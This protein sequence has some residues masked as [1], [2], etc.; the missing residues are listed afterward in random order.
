MSDTFSWDSAT[1]PL[2]RVKEADDRIKFARE[3]RESIEDYNHHLHD[4]AWELV[5]LGKSDTSKSLLELIEQASL[6]LELAMPGTNHR[7]SDNGE[8]ADWFAE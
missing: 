4:P 1:M 8:I 2:K 6:D 5:R 3:Q 7:W